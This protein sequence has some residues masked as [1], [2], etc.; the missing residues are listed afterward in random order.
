MPNQFHTRNLLYTV[1]TEKTEAFSSQSTYENDYRSYDAEK[2]F[3]HKWPR[4]TNGPQTD[5]PSPYVILDHS[6]LSERREGSHI[7]FNLYWEPKPIV[8]RN[9]HEKLKAPELTA[10]VSKHKIQTSTILAPAVHISDI[11]DEDIK[12]VVVRNMYLTDWR[13]AEIEAAAKI[14]KR[15][16]P[17]ST[18]E[19]EHMTDL[20]YKPNINPAL[21][22]GWRERGGPWDNKQNRAII[23]STKAFW[24]NK[25]WKESGISTIDEKVKEEIH[26]LLGQDN[27]NRAFDKIS[28]TY[29]GHR[30]K[31][32]A[33][34]GL[35][36]VELP[37]E[38]PG[39][40][41]YQAIMIRHRQ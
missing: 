36:K 18:V 24:L 23:D 41:S 9:P 25:P 10:N 39:V 1:K 5:K 12:S 20:R 22:V 37:I 21:S 28:I 33:R 4:D 3:I 32:P 13:R 27:L 19:S 11:A 17:D 30:P 8:G 14:Q 29:G 16:V 2:R 40:S 6:T 26:S 35:R 15:I 7:P 38:H 34:S 31:C